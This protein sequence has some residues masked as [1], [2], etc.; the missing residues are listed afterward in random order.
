MHSGRRVRIQGSLIESV[1]I[2]GAL[3]Q[4]GGADDDLVAVGGAQNG[5]EHDPAEGEGVAVCVVG[6]GWGG[7][8]VG[9]GGCGGW[10]VGCVRGSDFEHSLRGGEERGFEIVGLV[11]LAEDRLGVGR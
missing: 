1:E 5:M 4:A 9:G 2:A 6:C 3:V 10:I 11:D 7:W 8:I